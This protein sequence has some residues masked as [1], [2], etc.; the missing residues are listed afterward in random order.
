MSLVET[1][2]VGA[3]PPSNTVCI[4]F[5]SFIKL[6]EGNIDQTIS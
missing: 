5:Q 6:I 3:S 4:N 1:I 2:K